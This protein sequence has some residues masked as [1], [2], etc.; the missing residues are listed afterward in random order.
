MN[1][2]FDGQGTIMH[3][4]SR[5]MLYDFKLSF[6]KLPKYIEKINKDCRVALERQYSEESRMSLLSRVYTLPK[7]LKENEKLTELDIRKYKSGFKEMQRFMDDY[8]MIPVK[9]RIISPEL[10]NALKKISATYFES[11]N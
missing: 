7:Y 3:I 8:W 10:M 1:T 4:K 2:G 5:S 11:K 9:E 6:C